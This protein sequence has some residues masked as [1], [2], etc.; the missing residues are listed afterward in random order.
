MK[1]ILA[2]VIFLAVLGAAS[3][4]AEGGCPDRANRL[5]DFAGCMVNVRGVG[6][7]YRGTLADLNGD[8]HR[9][10]MYVMNTR[11]V[12]GGHS[13]YMPAGVFAPMVSV[14]ASQA[15]RNSSHSTF[16]TWWTMRNI[17]G[18]Y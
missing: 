2:F 8:S 18:Y 13:V 4:H 14:A 11:P 17:M 7:M 1:E 3:G 10:L 6:P 16:W 15:Y 5:E 12:V 9:D